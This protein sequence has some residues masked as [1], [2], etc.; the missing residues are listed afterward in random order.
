MEGCLV[1]RKEEEGIA[2]AWLNGDEGVMMTREFYNPPEFPSSRV[3]IGLAQPNFVVKVIPIDSPA[4]R[5]S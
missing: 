1:K 2:L 4:Q 3:D 5:T